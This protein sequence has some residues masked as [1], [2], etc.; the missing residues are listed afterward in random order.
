MEYITVFG[1]AG[2]IGGNIVVIESKDINLLFDFGKDFEQFNLYFNFPDRLPSNSITSELVKTGILPIL[3]KH[4]G[5]E[6]NA[7]VE[8]E[9]GSIIKDEDDNTL[10]DAV[11]ISHAHS[12]HCGMVNLLRRNIDVFMGRFTRISYSSYYETSS[13]RTIDAK[14][15]FKSQEDRQRERI[16][17][18]TFSSKDKIKIS[19]VTV[20]PYAVDHST[21]G[22]YAFIIETPNNVVAYTG[23]FRMHGV[24]RSYTEEFVREL[25]G[26]D[27]IDY[28]IC[29]GTNIAHG[30]T[31]SEEG[32][33]KDAKALISKAL[34]M[35]SKLIMVDVR[36][37][38]L[39]R[40]STFYKIGDELNFKIVISTRLAYLLNMI[41]KYKVKERIVA[42]LPK[43]KDVPV[44]T[45][46]KELRGWE[47]R[48][49]NESY[50]E[51]FEKKDIVNAGKRIMIIDIGRINV[52][53]I[54]PP[55]GSIYIRSTSEHVSEEEEAGEESFINSL[56]LNGIISYT[57][58]SSGHI[59]PL[60]L[61]Q[62]VKRVK[63][64]KII[65]IHTEYPEMFRELF[66]RFSDVMIPQKGIPIKLG[67]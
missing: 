23:D 9:E 35:G 32:V 58:H 1:G 7:I 42:K 38:D 31:T 28:L 49:I 65:P 18:N 46:R 61:V 3:R 5:K 60:E 17:F 33:R 57:L 13:V 67:G 20:R 16:K 50:A 10:L 12:D 39:D 55:V 11:F 59:S 48:L 45:L 43:V 66:G 40:I 37:T 15:Y 64:R 29:E 41:E 53:E 52:F 8:F 51:Y 36:S 14:L 25:E 4:D 19:D 26:Y 56:A 54:K 63:P 27:K 2:R 30:R 24:V 6:L 22:S 62:F 44:L 47:K 34:N 21:P